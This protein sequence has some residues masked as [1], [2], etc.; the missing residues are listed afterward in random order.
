MKRGLKV[1]PLV[2]SVGVALP[3]AAQEA[4]APP[5][6][7]LAPSTPQ[8][9]PVPGGVA[10][11]YHKAKKD[12]N[13]WRFDFH[14]MLMVPLRF[15]IGERQAVGPQQQK[16]TLHAPPVVPDS[17]DSFNYT[18][19][20]PESYVGLQ[21]TYGNPVVTGN[22]SVVSRQPKMGASFFD[23]PKNPGIEDAYLEFQ[24]AELM[25]NARFSLDIGAFS[26]RYGTMGEWDEGRYGTPLIA[27]TNGIGEAINAGFSFGK[28]SL[29]VSQEIQGQAD[30]PW[31][32]ITPDYSNDFADWRTGAG[33]VF[34]EHI[35]VG[36]DGMGVLGLHHMTAFT[37]DDRASQNGQ[38]DGRVTILGADLRLTLS[39]FG[40][41]Y[42]GAVSHQ[43][44][45]ARSL[46]RIIEILNVDSGRGLIEQ[47]FG[48]ASAATGSLFTL[49]AQ[50]DLSVSRLLY[51]PRFEG[52]GPDIVVSL[53]GMQTKVSSK[54][55]GVDPR[56]G[57]SLY[58]G[59][60]K[61]KIGLEAS[62][63]LLSWLA[64]STRMDQVWPDIN[65]TDTAFAQ[66]S[67]RLLF[68]SGWNARDQV[69][70][71]YTRFIYGSQTVVRGGFPPHDDPTLIPDKHL[72]ALTA[73]LWW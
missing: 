34:G 29:V 12:R 46:G 64:V 50:Y 3:A 72:L 63:S 55:K 18:G 51:G 69:A 11:A 20:V 59:V 5:V 2:F 40:H 42:L 23:P 53:F 56:D 26:Q 9:G 35:G 73:S 6:L 37:Q 48:P 52:E 47:Y 28:L 16:M 10:P 68:R 49:G 27:R 17:R 1:L 13:D 8:A 32:G 45:Y 4:P 66:V 33:Y 31:N 60:T 70:L 15:S 14:G 22:I 39:R 43:A 21:F 25:R 54:D 67:P 62:Y 61:R 19:T 38:P 44:D 65:Y 58:D 36:W 30:R 7:G 57:H 41:L 71:S 24:L